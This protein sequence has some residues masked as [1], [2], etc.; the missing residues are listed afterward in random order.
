MAG[1]NESIEDE[2]CDLWY[3]LAYS[4]D[5]ILIVKLW[6]NMK[7]QLRGVSATK[8]E[9]LYNAIVDGTRTVEPDE[10]AN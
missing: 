8:I 1:V 4:P 9:T 3:L 5:Q 6:S 10:F 7:S 2:G